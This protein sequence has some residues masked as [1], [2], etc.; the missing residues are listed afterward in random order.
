MSGET[1]VPAIA[2]WAL[3]NA[4]VVVAK[5]RAETT[6]PVNGATTEETYG[7]VEVPPTSVDVANGRDTGCVGDKIPNTK[8][9]VS[10]AVTAPENVEDAWSSKPPLDVLV[11]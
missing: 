3:M 9:S 4:F 5:H 1:S 2:S 11:A 8:L 10:C 6:L 7:A